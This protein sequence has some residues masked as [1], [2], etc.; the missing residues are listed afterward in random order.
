MLRHAQVFHLCLSGCDRSTIARPVLARQLYHAIAGQEPLVSTLSLPT[1]LIAQ[2]RVTAAVPTLTLQDLPPG[3]EAIPETQLAPIKEQ[4]ARENLNVESVFG[5]SQTQSVQVILGFTV[6]IANEGDVASF[7]RALPNQPQLMVR[8]L[9]S[10]VGEEANLQEIPLTRLEGIGNNVA[11]VGVQLNVE[12]LP[13]RI[14]ALSFRRDRR[15]ATIVVMYLD[16]EPP[17]I[18]TQDIARRL[19]SR[20]TGAASSR[21]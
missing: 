19:D 16:G 7:D 10:Y 12:G 21:R 3:F 11:G 1:S 17:T 4:F 5:F 20:L 18:T 2:G 13:T 8:S 14:D 9:A 15:V 6:R